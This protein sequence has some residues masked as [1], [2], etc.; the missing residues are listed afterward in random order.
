MIINIDAKTWHDPRMILDTIPGCEVASIIGD[1]LIVTPAS[2]ADEAAIIAILE[3][4][5][6]PAMVAVRDYKA[7]YQAA[8]TTEERI[9]VIAR[10]LGLEV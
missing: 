6:P 10:K 4:D 2:G 7:D 9:F 5:T 8:S 3:A 1:T